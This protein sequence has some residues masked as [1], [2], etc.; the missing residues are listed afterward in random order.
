ME[1]KMKLMVPCNWDL[2]LLDKT[3][4][5]PIYDFYGAMHTSP[6]GH[7]RPALIIPKVSEEKAT[8]FIKK[9][10][11]YGSSF[12]YVLNAPNMGNLEFDPKYHRKILNYLQWL[13]DIGVDSVHIANPYL[14]EIVIEQFPELKLGVSVVTGVDS[15]EIAQ[16][17]EKMGADA[18]NLSL[19][20]NRDFKVLNAIRR[21]VDIPLV[22]I[23]NLADL[24]RCHYRTYHYSILGYNSNTSS[25][26]KAWRYWALQP[27]KMQCNEKKLSDPVE[28]MK[29]CFIRPEDLKFYDE[30]GIDI[31]KLSGRHQNTEWIMRVVESYWNRKSPSNLA[32]II[33][34]IVL[35]NKTTEEFHSDFILKSDEEIKAV[36]EFYS[37]SAI[38][39]D[40]SK[41]INI[42][43]KAL[44]GFMDYF[45]EEGCDASKNCDE[46]KYCAKWVDKAITIDEE[47]ANIYLNAIKKHRKALKTSKFARELKEVKWDPRVEQM[48]TKFTQNFPKD[49][50]ELSKAAVKAQTEENARIRQSDTINQADLIQAFRQRVPPQFKPFMEK[51]FEQMGIS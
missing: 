26:K 44:D 27:C 17:F 14:M 5:I 37:W 40:Q 10:H 35:S 48:F 39:T 30:I 16:R 25:I 3:K 47:M 43:S 1:K 51:A 12:S 11:E 8:Q 9:T 2:D 21:A 32:D 19:E 7:G 50:K 33:D 24:R 46:C 13:V 4:D 22:I 42:D 29:S 18:I 15:V 20:I 41:M 49:I 6:V 45:V 36:P 34:S 28:I 38:N 31:Y 23:P